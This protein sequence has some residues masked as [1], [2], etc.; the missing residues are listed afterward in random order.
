MTALMSNEN[1]KKEVVN[2]M[3]SAIEIY[4]SSIKTGNKVL[5]TILTEK[6]LSCSQNKIKLSCLVDGEDLNFISE[7]DLFTFLEM[8]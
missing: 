6:S 4:D 1:L 5:D 7:I 3:A 8:L 2:E